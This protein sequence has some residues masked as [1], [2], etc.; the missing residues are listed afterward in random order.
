MEE[1]INVDTIIKDDLYNIFKDSIICPLCSN[2][3]INPVMCLTCQ[4]VYCKR[5]IDKWS[6]SNQKC[7]NGCENPNYQK[8]IGKNDILSKLKIKC[9]KCEKI[10]KHY[11]TCTPE[12]IPA[13]EDNKIEEKI[14]QQKEQ[15]FKKISKEEID[16]FKKQGKDIMYITSKL[17]I[18]NLFFN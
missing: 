18:L 1:L 2:I 8:N 14:S 17:F 6:E 15:K 7:Q 16:N 12:Q 10:S 3:L 5:C 11:D 9:R 4:K 13:E